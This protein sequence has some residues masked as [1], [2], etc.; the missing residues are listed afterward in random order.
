VR[1]LLRGNIFMD[2]DSEGWLNALFGL[3]EEKK[4][5]R[6]SDLSRLSEKN[7]AYP[8][9]SD[10]LA[11]PPIPPPPS[12]NYLSALAKL[13]KAPKR[14]VFISY[15]HGNDQWAYDYFSKT[16][17][18]DLELFSDQSLDG[19]IR[20]NDTEYVN[21][22]IREDYIVG[23]SITIVLCGSETGKRKYVDWEI[24]STLHQKH[25]P[26]EIQRKFPEHQDLIE[27]LQAA[28]KQLL[29]LSQT[30]ERIAHG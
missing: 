19:K 26:Q 2:K 9:L 7:A 21:R 23:S 25:A 5:A 17:G 6:L 11:P 28:N 15:H 1:F 16:Y 20:S 30:L 12:T 8:R 29:Q 3:S 14:K 10:L 4:T 13:A 18:E 27:D 22:A 24:R